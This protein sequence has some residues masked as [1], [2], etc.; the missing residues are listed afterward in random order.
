MSTEIYY[1]SGTGNSFYVAQELQK[2]I[3]NT[4]LIPIVSL[5]NKENIEIDS[6]T[7]G[8]VFP[9]HLAM[10]P[11]PV[12][13][14]LKKIDLN[15][16][17]YIF[18]VA[19]RIGSRNRASKDLEIILKKKGKY[20]SSFFNL[21]MASNDPKFKGFKAATD[22]EIADMEVKVQNKLNYIQNIVE[23]KEIIWEEDTESTVQIPAFTI[24]SIFLPYLN[25]IFKYDFFA[26]TKCKGCGTCE[27]V[28]LSNRIKIV[29]GKPLW[30]K[31]VKCFFCYACLNYCPQYAVQIKSTR[32]FRTY[33]E[34]NE[35]YSH[36][37]AT[38]DDIVIQ[39]KI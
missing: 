27:K 38:A 23:N 8:L 30:Q 26:N 11:N 16:V 39:K 37:Y 2:R 14:F 22:Y 15:S 24:L 1:F 6:D 33:T 36:P 9:I 31:D 28:C 7:V 29:D 34:E 17:K 35:R 3:P 20:L 13:K 18:A 12:L 19:T 5:L 4:E 21:N 32:M 10:A 25:K